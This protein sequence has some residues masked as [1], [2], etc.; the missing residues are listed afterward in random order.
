[1]LTKYGIPQQIV[2]G[3]SQH[4]VGAELICAVG[5]TD[6]QTDIPELRYVF[7]GPGQRIAT[8]W[9]IRGMNPSG[10]EARFS[11]PVQTDP[12]AHPASCLMGTMSLPGG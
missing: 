10:G 1:M 9:T 4:P 5:L 3:V 2:I 7:R 6:G 11:A 12:G 8:N